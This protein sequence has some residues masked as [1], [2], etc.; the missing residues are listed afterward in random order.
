MGVKGGRKRGTAII[1]FLET[2]SELYQKLF[3]FIEY[4][5]YDKMT[6]A[7]NVLGNRSVNGD[8]MIIPFY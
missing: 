4:F 2:I 5:T 6:E 8:T 1:Y 3:A 7:A